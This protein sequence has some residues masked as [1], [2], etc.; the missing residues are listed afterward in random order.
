MYAL[1]IAAD[2][3]TLNRGDS[4]VQVYPVVDEILIQ[5]YENTQL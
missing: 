4:F 1:N 5:Y 2:L 3:S